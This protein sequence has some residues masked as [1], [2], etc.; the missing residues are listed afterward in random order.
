VRRDAAG[1]LFVIIAAASWS[2]SGAS[3]RW[4][5]ADGKFT[6]LS[7]AFWRDLITFACLLV[8]LVLLCPAL[9]RIKGRDLPWLIAL[10]TIG[11][12]TFHILWNLSIMHNGYA[13]ATI[14]IRIATL[15]WLLFPPGRSCNAKP[16]DI[17]VI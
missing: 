11:I 7:L 13:A 4:I 3:I 16:T 15:C 17:R 9:L 5:L 1:Y 14:V 2:T 6:P 10:G 12:G 8:G